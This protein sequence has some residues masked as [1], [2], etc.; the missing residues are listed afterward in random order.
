MTDTADA[1]LAGLGVLVTG[2]SSGIGRAIAIACARAGADVALTYRANE[3]GVQETAREV[4]ARGR[5]AVILQLDLAEARSVGA[6]GPAARDALGRLDVWVNNAGADILTGSG[7]SLPTIEKLDLLLTVDLRGTMLASWQA[8]DML[9]AQEQGGVIINLSWDHVLT[10]M[11]GANPQLY[12]AV[13]GG[14]LA[15]SKS[16]ARSVAPRVRVNILAP[17]WIETSFA[18]GANERLRHQ[19]AESTPLKRWGMPEDVAG[20]AVF[21]AS[22]AAAF[23]TGQTILVGGGVVM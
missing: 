16:L 5:R 21:L 8:A 3:Q 13:K 14:V 23:L 7:A 2:A 19:V 20:A 4:R 22:P 11:A 10:G 9:G 1:A 18:A 6:L 15:F 12:A 17:G